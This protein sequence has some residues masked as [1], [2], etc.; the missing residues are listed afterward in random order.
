MNLTNMGLG[1]PSFLF[2]PTRWLRLISHIGKSRMLSFW[3]INWSTISS[4]F[5][6]V[7]SGQSGLNIRIAFRLPYCSSSSSSNVSLETSVSKSFIFSVFFSIWRSGSKLLRSSYY[8][9]L[10]PK[11]QF[12]PLKLWILSP[13]VPVHICSRPPF[14]LIDAGE[15]HCWY[16]LYTWRGF[17]S[18]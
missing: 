10:G 3:W 8:H 13:K 15:Q 6:S 18:R 2:W 16:R 1:V 11:N 9:R 17:Q 7:C 4:V 14:Q 5:S 12:S